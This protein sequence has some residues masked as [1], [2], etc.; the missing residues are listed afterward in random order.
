MVDASR[1]DKQLELVTALRRRS[2]EIVLD[3]KTAELAAPGR[4]EGR[5]RQAP[6]AALSDGHVLGPEY[7]GVSPKADVVGAIARFAVSRPV[8]AILAPTHWLGD[9]NFMTWLETDALSCSR[10]RDALD[11]EGGKHIAIDYPLIAPH[12]FLQSSEEQRRIIERLRDIPF[13]N[14]WVRASGFRNNAAPLTTRWHIEALGKLHVLERPIVADYLGGMTGMAMLAFGAA[15]AISHGIAKFE[16]FDAGDW[17]RA[18]GRTTRDSPHKSQSRISLLDINRSL[19]A[20]ELRW[21]D[22]ARGARKHIACGDRECCPNGFDDMLRDP[23]RHA[24]RQS[25]KLIDTLGRVPD[26]KRAD[27]FVDQQFAAVERR[28]RHVSKL[29]PDLAANLGESGKIEKLM[30]RLARHAEALEKVHS[31]VDNLRLES[32]GGMSRAK[33]VRERQAQPDMFSSMGQQ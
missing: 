9:L 24:A 29:K 26:L 14:L 30:K 10:L 33:P 2:V 16:G 3:P 6:W 17:R 31:A 19:T 25:R 11:R 28:A 32:V 23:R 12:T 20:T 13:E 4:F 5:V 18:L 8:D 15:S 7:F 22:S 1:L 21:L 27:H